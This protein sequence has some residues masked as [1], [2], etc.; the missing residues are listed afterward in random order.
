[1]RNLIMAIVLEAGFVSLWYDQ[2]AIL[3]GHLEMR[4]TFI[5]NAPITRAIDLIKMRLGAR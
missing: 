2:E 5:H 3:N 4:K 1:M